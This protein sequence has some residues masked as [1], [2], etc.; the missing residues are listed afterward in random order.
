MDFASGSIFECPNASHI[1][2]HDRFVRAGTRD[3]RERHAED[4]GVF[5][6]E[7]PFVV[8]RV[9]HPPQSAADHLLAQKLS[10]E[11]SHAENVRDR[12]RVPTFGQHRHAD[13][14]LDVLAE[15]P[16]LADGVHHLAQQVFVLQVV[17]IATGKANTIVRFE[18]FDLGGGDL[19][20]VVAHR[21][22]RFQ[23]LAIDQNRVRS[24]RPPAIDD[25]AEYRQLARYEHRRLVRQWFL[26]SRDEVEHELRD[27]GVVADDDEDRRCLPF[28]S[29]GHVLFPTP[30]LFFVV[31]V[32]RAQ[33]SFQRTGKLRDAGKLFGLATLLGQLIADVL[34]QVAIRRLLAD[35]AIVFHGDARHFDDARFN[36][37]DQR[38]VGD[39][40][41]EK[42]PFVVAR[43]S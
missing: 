19:L 38:E 40:P 36:G 23:L 28:G 15:L 34:P 4:F 1:L 6:I 43:T 22:A 32:E 20:E 41:R 21:L 12:V 11:G 16:R 26:V 14:A 39:H 10:P 18:F 8:E 13:D 7:H 2:W 30:I 42:R 25:V 37:V 33:G 27:A 5:R 35:H 17:G 29:R 3:E 9:A 24:R 31:A